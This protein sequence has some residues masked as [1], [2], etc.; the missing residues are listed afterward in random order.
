MCPTVLGRLHT[1]VAILIGPAILGSA[2]AFVISL[3]AFVLSFYKKS[4]S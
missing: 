3:I 4:S 1:R 2:I